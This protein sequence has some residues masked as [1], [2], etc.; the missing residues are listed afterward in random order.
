[1]KL[2][3][4]RHGDPN[5]TLDCL[6]ELGH[7]Q[8]DE[9]SDHIRNY[10][11]QKIFTKLLVVDGIHG[12]EVIENVIDRPNR[13]DVLIRIDMDKDALPAYDESEPH[14]EWKKEFGA[15]L[16]SKAIFDYE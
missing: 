10:S 3:F 1:M 14:K 11:I 13:Y 15:L 12:V 16:E 2:Y 9:L 6:T 8:A 4:I 7:R 5:Y